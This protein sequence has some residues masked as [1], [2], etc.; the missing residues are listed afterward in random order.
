MS[1]HDPDLSKRVAPRLPLSLPGTFIGTQGNF[2]CIVTNLSRT[3]ALVAMN[4]SLKVG[5]DGYLRSGPIDRFVT[6]TRQDRGFN[7]VEFDIPVPD[8]FVA[9]MRRYQEGFDQHHRD[10]LAETVRSWT[11]GEN[12]GRW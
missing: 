10:E 6:V 12:L 4:E 9:D 5:A 1:F 7:A 8:T 2:S 3:G 11:T